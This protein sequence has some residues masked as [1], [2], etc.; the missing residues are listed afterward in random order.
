MTTLPSIRLRIGLVDIREYHASLDDLCVKDVAG[1]ARV[2][3]GALLQQVHGRL[4][5]AAAISVVSKLASIIVMIECR[6][7]DPLDH[8]AVQA[9]CRNVEEI[10]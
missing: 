5:G 3:L 8:D 9:E 7:V 1:P 6:I 2:D 10:I 4:E